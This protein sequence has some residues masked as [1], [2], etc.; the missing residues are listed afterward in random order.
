[1]VIGHT[2]RLW[3]SRSHS[4]CFRSCWRGGTWRPPECHHCED[5]PRASRRCRHRARQ[6]CSV[7]TPCRHGVRLTGE[8]SPT[9]PS[10]APPDTS[11]MRRAWTCTPCL[12]H[13]RRS[14]ESLPSSAI[15]S[16]QPTTLTLSPP[17]RH[18]A[19]TCY[20]PTRTA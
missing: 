5:R 18:A 15:T 4:R 16:A 14:G 10:T 9:S 1:M 2:S 17:M 7:D 13:T 12:P 20:S 19:T 3:I 6:A 11:S 8:T